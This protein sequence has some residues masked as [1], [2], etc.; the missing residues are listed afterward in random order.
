MNPF[1]IHLVNSEEFKWY[2]QFMSKYVEI[3]KI[4]LCYW[5]NRNHVKDIGLKNGLPVTEVGLALFL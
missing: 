5:R 4:K 3:E 1:E 2:K